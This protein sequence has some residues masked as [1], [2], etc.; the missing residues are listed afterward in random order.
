MLEQYDDV[1]SAN[2]LCEILGIGRNRAYELLQT[3]QIKGFQMGRP[4]KIPKVS[5]EEYLKR[6]SS[7]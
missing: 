7:L 1:I 2:E 5:V 3:N 6:K 4:W